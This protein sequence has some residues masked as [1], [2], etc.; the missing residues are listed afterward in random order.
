MPLPVLDKA[1]T[2]NV[3]N[4][5]PLD[6][7]FT[8]SNDGEQ[9]TNDRKELL[10]QIKDA[11]VATAFWSVKLSSNGTTPGTGAG[12]N[13]STIADE[14]WALDTGSPNFAWTV[15]QNTT[16]DLEIL[17]ICRTTSNDEGGHPT[18]YISRPTLS[19]GSGFTGG[20]ANARP[21]ATDESFIVQS[22]L[23]GWGTND[24]SGKAWVFSTMVSTDGEVTR[25]AW[26]NANEIRGFWMFERLKNPV[27][28]LS[29]PEIVCKMMAVDQSSGGAGG[30]DATYAGLY[31]V[32]TRAFSPQYNGTS[33]V[34]Q[35]PQATSKPPGIYMTSES[36]NGQPC[37]QQFVSA[38]Q[39]DG[40]YGF[41]PVGMGS[42]FPGFA[43]R[44][45][46]FFDLWWGIEGNATGD[47]YPVAGTNLFIQIN[48]L[49]LPWNGTVP[50]VA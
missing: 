34:Q 20:A 6:G 3:N 10:L 14:L 24:A 49:I 27:S 48:D 32:D 12:D 18:V 21:T 19:G 9:P 50:V 41:F 35:N 46:E 30:A 8:P 23:W 42:L 5:I 15:L 47:T 45:A 7:G 28:G 33:P 2:F 43:G 31:D 11:L 40:E 4:V 26:F 17:I 13:W 36:F 29:S 1:Y 44:N 16:I 37:G 25:V 38:N 22:E 39:V